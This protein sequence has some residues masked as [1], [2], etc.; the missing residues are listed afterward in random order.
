MSKELLEDL[1]IE[2]DEMGYEPTTLCDTE[3]EIE[4]YRSRLKKALNYFKSIDN[5][6]PSEALRVLEEIRTRFSDDSKGNNSWGFK[7]SKQLN[8]IKQ[9]L[10][11]AQEQEK[12]LEIIFKKS[13]MIY[14]LKVCDAVDEYN[15]WVTTGEQ[16]TEE[17]FNLLKAYF[18]KIIQK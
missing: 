6:N 5:A 4:S 17:E 14:L 10:L 2:F 12:V 7:I 16:L 13:V 15:D 3:R 9:A 18:E 11:K 1:L 8:T